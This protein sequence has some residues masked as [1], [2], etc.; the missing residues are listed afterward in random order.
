MPLLAWRGHALLTLTGAAFVVSCSNES[1]S[2]PLGVVADSGLQHSVAC[3]SGS[4]TIT[5]PNTSPVPL[6]DFGSSYVL[7]EL[8]FTGVITATPPGGQP[9]SRDPRG[10]P[11]G[12]GCVEGVYAISSTDGPWSAGPCT[13]SGQQ[14]PPGYEMLRGAVNALWMGPVPNLPENQPSY[15]GD[16]T[17]SYTR[18][19]GSGTA[20]A[21]KWVLQAPGAVTFT[22]TI[23]PMTVGGGVQVP[24]S[25]HWRWQP[26][27][28]GGGDPAANCGPWLV[29][30]TT[31]S[32]SGTMYADFII[33][34]EATSKAVR[35]AVNSCPPTGD[36]WLD[37]PDF[38]K[39]LE[40]DLAASTP[41]GS[42]PDGRY[43]TPGSWWT[44]DATGR[45]FYVPIPDYTSDNCHY[46]GGWPSVP[47]A[48]PG[49]TTH[50]HPY[51]PWELIPYCGTGQMPIGTR[52]LPA[53]PSNPDWNNANNHGVNGCIIEVGRIFCYPPGVPS[54]QR[55]ANVT[56]Y[57]KQP[58]GCYAKQP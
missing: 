35:I 37:N 49:V 52:Y 30:T 40:D 48:T 41:D 51:R 4:V 46:T 45:P 22:A 34:G 3:A 26:D 1:T 57:K 16:F 27:E 44:D 38:R 23:N 25:I 29:C 8:A 14:P 9:Y 2:G 54:G 58:D 20:I 56:K 21:D 47:G 5:P 18:V 43:E 12:N 28:P 11:W 36:P 17:V 42:I 33:N 53:T 31:I 6:C 24:Y 32:A 19:T 15:S 7:V 50:T 39:K 10:W 55:G 13:Q